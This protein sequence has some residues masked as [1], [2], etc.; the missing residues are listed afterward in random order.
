MALGWSGATLTVAVVASSVVLPG[1]ALAADA[2]RVGPIPAWVRS[3]PVD[4]AERDDLKGLP[5]AILLHDIQVSFQTDSWTE[6]HEIKA[7]VQTPAGLQALGAIPF[8]WSPWSDTLTFHRASILRQGQPT[9]DVLPKDGA[10][11]VLR[12]ETGLEQAMLTGVLTAVLQPEGLQ[13]GDMLDLVISIRHA[14]PLLQGRTAALIANWDSAP[15]SRVRLEAHWPSALDVRWRETAGLPPLRRSEAN[16]VTTVALDLDDVHPPILP[17]HAPARFQHGRQIEFTTFADWK[18]VAQVMTPLF[19]KAADLPPQ[20]AVAAQA[21]AIAVTTTDPK[22]RAAAALQLVEDQVRYLAHAEAG[23]GY[24]PQSAEETWRLRYGDCKAKTALLIALLRELGVAAEPVLVNMTAGDGLDAHLPSTLPFDH[25]LVRVKL[26]GRDYWLD[27]SRQGD[28]SLDSLAT[29]AFGWVLPLG[30]DD[31]ELVHLVPPPSTEP[32]ITQLIAYDASGGVTAPEPTRLQ[33]TFRGDAAIILHALLVAIPPD[34]MD[35][36]LKG[37]WTKA[38]TAFTPTM[39]AAVWDPVTSE[40]KVTAQGTSKLDWTGSG[41]ELQSVEFGGA[42]DIKRDPASSDI[43]APYVVE[44]PS[45]IETDESVVLPPGDTMS[46]AAAKD[47]YVDTVIAG[48]A[49][50]RS[51]T[52]TG[53]VFKVMASQR[54]LQP[55][56]TAMQARASVEPLT[57]LGDQGVYAPAGPATRAADTASAID[58]HPTT[59]E[60][61]LTRGHALLG[62]G[63]DQEARAEFDAAISLDSK[64]QRA[65][66]GRAVAEAWLT[67]PA[68]AADADK[69]DSLGPP[70]IVAAQARAL[71]AEQ[72][73]E[74]E[75]ARAAYRRSLSLGPDDIFTLHHL[76][77]VEL[78][79]SDIEEARRDLKHLMRVDPQET[80]YVH[81]WG[82]A[83]EEAEH[84]KEAAERELAQMP[85]ATPEERLERAKEYVLL[86]DMDL[87]RADVDVAIAAKPSAAAWLVRASADGGF[88]S[89][90]ANADVEAAIKLAPDNEDALVWQAQAAGARGDYAAAMPVIDRLLSEHAE[91]DGDFR[92]WRAQFEGKL[93]HKAEMDADFTHARATAGVAAPQ[94]SYLCREEVEMKWRAEVAIA[95]CERALGTLPTAAVRQ[96]VI[97]LLHR[98]GREAEAERALSTME[99][100][101]HDPTELNSLC[102]G[103]AGENMRLDRAIADC[104]A[105]LKL[106]P[107]DA[108]TLDSRAFTLMRMGRDADALAA[109]DAALKADP[110]VYTSLYGRGLVE[111]R[112]GRGPDAARDTA[113]ALAARPH[114]REDFAEMGIR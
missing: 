49:Y 2:P 109:Y 98:L 110:T 22:A 62:A 19:A 57:K 43:D 113:A 60:G 66:A 77:A 38:H 102:Y 108:A 80:K 41:L 85:V 9:I 99:A 69:A 5:T 107:N 78:R 73:G 67:N 79:S 64:S 48:V 71:L 18:A 29:P 94:A 47:V 24:S 84:H 82:A 68:A 23:G 51:A 17:A 88:A 92:V 45:T 114:M 61:H 83:I 56:I 74:L 3:A 31:A 111:A 14:D 28:R 50:H 58:S 86:G 30:A 104:D 12:R 75:T 72:L 32:Q 39:V 89:V 55:E 34:R 44:F 40:E 37:Y 36:A 90:A 103:L 112:L 93:G 95:D 26:G 8:Q 54:A 4:L 59:I 20:S 53:N 27:G 16:G 6:F 70:N 52:V 10:F 65:W 7:R 42:P 21:K 100:T 91:S 101:T 33:T 87:G 11:T 1:A 13:V 25:V 96:D 46:P 81:L 76:I 97:I 15:V 106:R 63:R 105:S 35:A